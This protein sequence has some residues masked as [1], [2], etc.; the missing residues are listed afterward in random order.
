MECL[1][2]KLWYLMLRFMPQLNNSK[3]TSKALNIFVMKMASRET[4]SPDLG[5]GI[6]PE[7]RDWSQ[8]IVIAVPERERNS[9]LRLIRRFNFIFT[10]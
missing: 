9:A 8:H 10:P 3:I 1:S 5:A 4:R 6:K 2:T 7:K